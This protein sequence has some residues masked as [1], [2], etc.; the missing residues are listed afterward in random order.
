MDV[1]IHHTDKNK[2]C[3]Y[4]F[5]CFCFAGAAHCC[6]VKM[7]AKPFNFGSGEVGYAAVRISERELLWNIN[8]SMAWYKLQIGIWPGVYRE[9][10]HD[11][12]CVW[13]CVVL[14]Y[15]RGGFAIF[16]FNAR[17]DIAEYV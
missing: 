1:W 10:E 4:V 2:M 16:N 14:A 6:D 9:R 15:V 8:Y 12:V 17:I 13:V 11:R 3:L 7:R 5:F